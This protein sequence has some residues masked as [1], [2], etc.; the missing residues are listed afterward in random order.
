MAYPISATRLNLYKSCP[1]SYYFRYERGL[2]EQSA[3]GS[4]ALGKAVHAALKDIYGDWNY[5]HPK[6][7]LEWFELMWQAHTG[8]LSSKQV[9]DGW[10]M[11]KG[12]FEQFIEPYP[13]MN[14]PLGV[15]QGIKGKFQVRYIEFVVRG[16]YDRLDYI[17]DGLELIDY[18]TTKQMSPPDA[19]DIQ[20]GLYD[21]LLK[22]VY[23]QALRKLS[24]IYLRSGEKKPYEV[25]PEHRRESQRLIENLAMQLHREE[26]WRPQEGQQCD[27]CSYERYCAAKREVPEP[28]PETARKPKGMQ[29]LLPL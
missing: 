27:R 28:L 14:K 19:I 5:G 17:E 10:S 9:D 29:L 3:F 18:K 13:S 2:K 11:L 22:Q 1:Q 26:E 4:P 15:E 7:S 24:L 16:Q 8:D 21:L 20:L 12:Y 6:P 23:G 25:T